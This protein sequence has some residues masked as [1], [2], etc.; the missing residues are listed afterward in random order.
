M[1]SANNHPMLQLQN[2]IDQLFEDTF[3][4]FGFPSRY[5]GSSNSGR[6]Q[7]P[8]QAT[9]NIGSDEKNYHINLEAPGLTENDISLDINENI[10]TISGEKKE[11]KES[12]DLNYYR[13]EHTY[14][15]FQRVLALPDDVDQ[16]GIN[17]TMKNGMLNI[18]VP[19][20]E[21]PTSETKQIPINT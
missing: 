17:A 18:T 14:G 8:F 5:L 16:D 11:E 6:Q 21:S 3:R 1:T 10:L 2:E 13:I 20:R 12:K 9:V 15:S 7:M 4:N 19:R